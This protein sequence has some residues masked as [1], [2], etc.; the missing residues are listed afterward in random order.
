MVIRSAVRY[1]S[2][3]SVCLEIAVTDFEGH[4]GCEFIAPS[5]LVDEVFC[6]SQDNTVE[7]VHVSSVAIEGALSGNGLSL[8]EGH[9][10]AVINAIGLFPHHDA[11]FLDLSPSFRLELIFGTYLFSFH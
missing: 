7:L 9:D 8:L 4:A 3:Q 10:R 11:A 5:E 2:L 6:H 1:S